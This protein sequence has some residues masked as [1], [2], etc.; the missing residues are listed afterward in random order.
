MFSDDAVEVQMTAS[1]SQIRHMTTGS[2]TIV[3]V[4]I[5]NK[6]LFMCNTKSFAAISEIIADQGNGSIVN[7]HSFET[8]LVVLYSHGIIS[9]MG[10]GEDKMKKEIKTQKITSSRI[11]D[12]QFSINAMRIA[13]LVSGGIKIFSLSDLNV[14]HLCFAN[15]YMHRNQRMKQ[16]I[17]ILL[18]IF[19]GL[20]MKVT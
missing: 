11:M 6:K 8:Q 3:F 18:I 17:H 1:I 10:D 12:A 14:F 15:F 16:L 7:Y 13:I 2:E 4:V 19:Y 9:V 20:L 5:G